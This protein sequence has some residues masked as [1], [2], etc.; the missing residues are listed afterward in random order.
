MPEPAPA[1][2]R[3]GQFYTTVSW[4]GYAASLFAALQIL[5]LGYLFAQHMVA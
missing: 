4:T 2:Q 3:W 5:F 1:L